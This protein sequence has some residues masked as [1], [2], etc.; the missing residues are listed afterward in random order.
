MTRAEARTRG[1]PEKDLVPVPIGDGLL[2]AYE[3]TGMNL[4]GTQLVNLTACQTG[5]GELTAAEGIAGLRSAFLLAGARAITM[6]LWNVPEDKTLRQMDDFYSEWME[7]AARGMRPSDNQSSLPCNEPGRTRAQATPSG[8]P[9][10]CTSAIP[11]TS[12]GRQ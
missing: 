12:R 6:S 8:G 5:L 9:V 11:A 3:V 10:S 7:K 4:R 1:L 2:T